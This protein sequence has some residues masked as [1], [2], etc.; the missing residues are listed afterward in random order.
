M[1]GVA[2]LRATFER[3]RDEGRVTLL[4]YLVAGYPDVATSISAGEALLDAGADAL[5]IGVPFSDPV[6]DGPLIAE[7]GRQAIVAGGGLGAARGIARRLREG[8]REAPLLVMTYRN[9]LL[10][11][12]DE[13]AAGLAADG[14][15]GLIVPDLPAGEEP[16][17]ER[18]ARRSGLAMTFLVAPNTPTARLRLVARHATG[19]VYVVPRYGV[20]G[21]VTAGAEAVALLGR[22]R[23]AIP[24]LPIAAG[25][26][27]ATPDDVRALAP[28]LDG[29]AVGTALVRALG[30]GGV[31]AMAEL[32]ASLAAA[33]VTTRA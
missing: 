10:A 26:G 27:I 33:T 1:S 6:A 29:V 23:A 5:E 7:A 22:V 2:R 21:A 17:L 24:H 8:G 31:N 18:A 15:D 30:T 32:A 13:L 4:A 11:A 3:V 14:V 16:A 25:F 28:H 19:F 20:T 12:G 9:P